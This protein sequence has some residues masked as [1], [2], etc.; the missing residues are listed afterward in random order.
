MLETRVPYRGSFNHLIH[1]DKAPKDVRELDGFLVWNLAPKCF[2]KGEGG[3]YK[4]TK[5]GEL[6]F[7]V[8]ALY[9]LSF[10][11]WYDIAMNDK[12]LPN[13]K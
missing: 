13:M 11:E 4:I 1:L 6:C 3:W 12:F 8:R 9:L 5:K 10:K 2:M 7:V